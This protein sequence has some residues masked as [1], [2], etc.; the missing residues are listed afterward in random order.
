LD[1]LPGTLLIIKFIEAQDGE[2]VRHSKPMDSA[3]QA[4][5]ITACRTPHAGQTRVARRPHL[6]GML[7]QDQ[8]NCHGSEPYVR[9]PLGL[10]GL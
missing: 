7:N 1:P 10:S 6:L 4:A 8:L 2:A 3:S 9:Q 5:T